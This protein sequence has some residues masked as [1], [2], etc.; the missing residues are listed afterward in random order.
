M[1]AG[2]NKKRM[3]NKVATKKGDAISAYSSKQIKE[4]AVICDILHAEID[5]IL[6][7][8]SSRIYYAMPVW[9]IDENPVV[10]YKAAS[11]HVNLMFWS[12][13]DFNETELIPLGKFKASQIKYR[14]TSDINIPA[15]RRWLRK[16]MENIWDYKNIRTNFRKLK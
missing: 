11:N 13:Q 10:S 1:P 16:A 6:K 15:L 9:F 4:Y 3:N 5:K 14:S 2:N 12:G 8:A 7:K